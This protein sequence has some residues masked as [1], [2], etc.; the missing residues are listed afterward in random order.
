MKKIIALFLQCFVLY[1]VNAN[2]VLPS[3]IGSNM[4]LQQNSRVKI[5]GWGNPLEKVFVTT[6]WDNKTDSAIVPP[7]AGWKITVHTPAAGGPY[8]ITIKGNNT[9]VLQNVLVGEVWVC[10]GQSNMEMSYG[11]GIPIMND[12]VPKAFN[13]NIHFFT[14]AK[15]SSAYPQDDCKGEWAVCDSNTV[16]AFSAAA[17]Y[18][19]KRL[20]KELNMPIGLIN[21]SWGATAADVWTPDSV[22][23]ADATLKEAAAKIKP[24]PWCAIKPGSVYNT[25]IAPL[26]NYNIAGVIWYQGESNTVAAASYTKLFTSMI[27]TWR[28]A[29]GKQ[30]PFYYVQIAPFKYG[31][32]N[33]AALLREAQ[34][35]SMSLNNTGMVVI[36]DI[37]GDT[38]DIHPKNKRDVGYRLAG[39]ALAETYNR[40]GLIYKNALYKSMDVK[41]GK[42]ILSFD[43][44]GSG[45]TSNDKAI[46]QVYIA[47]DDRVFY[48][49]QVTIDHD[50]LVVWSALVKQ[51]AAVRYAFGNTAVGNLF[52]PGNL[53]VNPF[54]TDNWPVDTSPN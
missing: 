11:W 15:A 1:A 17:Y 5:W 28:S 45:L 34:T 40:P 8:T 53:P 9:I 33:I 31:D 38:T 4:V 18:F 12:D 16:K 35:H 30:F 41:D 23:E 22:I 42:A 10:S 7:E 46:T 54:R 29:W 14:V 43:N 37:T 21:T 3:V 25:M 26:L 50:K 32:R 36:T 2:I 20:N 6:S 19:G 13:N 39:W 48:P 47:G 27:S 49:A 51:P 44:A 52:G 24:N